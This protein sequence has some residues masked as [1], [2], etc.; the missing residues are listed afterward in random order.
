MG[1]G[2]LHAGFKKGGLDVGGGG[3]VELHM[4]EP[5]GDLLARGC[6]SRHAPVTSLSLRCLARLAPSPL[7]DKRWARAAGKAVHDSDVTGACRERQP[8]A[9]RS[10]RGSSM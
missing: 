8:R 9:R 5:L 4:L 2:I 7:E 6:R 1:L 3:G 10:P